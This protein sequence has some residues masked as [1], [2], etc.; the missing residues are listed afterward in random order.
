M[1]SKGSSKRRPPPPILGERNSNPVF[2]RIV[3]VWLDIFLA[4]FEKCRDHLCSEN[5]M[6]PQKW[7]FYEDKH[8]CKQS[9]DQLISNGTRVIL[10]TSGSLGRDLISCLHHCDLLDSIYIYCQNIDKYKRF[11]RLHSKVLGVHDDPVA[12][13]NQLRDDLDKRL[14]QEFVPINGTL[15]RIDTCPDASVTSGFFWDPWELNLCTTSLNIQDHVTITI[16]ERKPIVIELILSTASQLVDI[17][18]ENQYSL[19]IE[20]NHHHIAVGEFINHEPHFLGRTNDAHQGLHS[21]SHLSN[22]QRVQ[23]IHFSKKNL[24]LTVGIGEI[25]P[26]FQVL[27]IHLP[28]KYSTLICSISYLH[29]KINKVWQ[30]FE[31]ISHLQDRFRLLIDSSPFIEPNLLVVRARQPTLSNDCSSFSGLTFSNL[32]EPLRTLY[33]R[34]THFKFDD[35][36]FPDLIQAIEYSLHQ[37]QGW[38][39]RQLN[40]KASRSPSAKRQMTCL[41]LTLDS[42]VIEIWPV[43]HF[44][45]IHHHKQAHGMFRVL[46]GCIL[47]RLFPYLNVQRSN[48]VLIE[49][50]LHREQMTWMT[51]LWNQTHQ[52]KNV[53]LDSCCI[54]LQCYD[55]DQPHQARD[56]ETL[57]VLVREGEQIQSVTPSSD[58]N[59]GAFKELIR[60]EWDRRDRH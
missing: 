19:T 11:S 38:C 57:D 34:L 17:G 59:F 30:N 31:K 40:E 4:D 58:M 51:P 10:V 43:G 28:T 13:L 6:Y 55:Y 22:E 20:L 8:K 14:S 41:R 53:D 5:P 32:D 21:S 48:D 44:S 27:Q 29:I 56:Q 37:P 35:E 9:I 23:W 33:N 15:N 12:L 39:H 7:L 16:I 24:T 42:L 3:F 36:T 47:I 25:R 26:N 1:A 18:G 2:D 45:P 54:L 60:Q 49:Y 52:M 50:L 46:Y